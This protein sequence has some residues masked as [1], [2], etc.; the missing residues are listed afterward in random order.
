MISFGSLLLFIGGL[1]LTILLNDPLWSGYWLF[2][3]L[4]LLIAGSI[5]FKA[6]ILYDPTYKRVKRVITQKLTI[7]EINARIIQIRTKGGL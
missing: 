1:Y 2:F 3:S 7:N 6:E 5:L 4:C